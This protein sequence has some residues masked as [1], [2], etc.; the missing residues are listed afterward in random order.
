MAKKFAI[1]VKQIRNA[2]KIRSKDINIQK[3]K[4]SNIQIESTICYLYTS[5]KIGQFTPILNNF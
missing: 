3:N 4:A 1:C 2:S 5:F